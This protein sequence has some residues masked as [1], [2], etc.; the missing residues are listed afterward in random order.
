MKNKNLRFAE[1]FHSGM[2]VLLAINAL[3]TFASWKTGEPV[4]GLFVCL[5]VIP[6][7]VYANTWAY[8]LRKHMEIDREEKEREIELF[9]IAHDRDTLEEE[10]RMQ[11]LAAESMATKVDA[12]ETVNVH[13]QHE[14][15]RFSPCMEKHE[16]NLLG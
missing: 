11:K 4:K 6:V 8:V 16:L 3:A 2:L 7:L 14:L 10:I 1:A 12:L 9:K 15:R 5:S 13:L